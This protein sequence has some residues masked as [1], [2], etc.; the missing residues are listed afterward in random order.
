MRRRSI[1][2]VV[3]VVSCLDT[4]KCV[5]VKANSE[6]WMNNHDACVGKLTKV[7]HV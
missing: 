5:T 4:C 6:L 3:V 2:I 7:L 1:Y